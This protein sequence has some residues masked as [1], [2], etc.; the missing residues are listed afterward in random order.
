MD[1]HRYKADVL[2]DWG[3]LQQANFEDLKQGENQK[4]S[5][6]EQVCTACQFVNKVG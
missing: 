3:V 2:R 5:K 4:N 1:S 6:S